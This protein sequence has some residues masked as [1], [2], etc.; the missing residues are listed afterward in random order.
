LSKEL[1]LA[2]CGL[3]AIVG[4]YLTSHNWALLCFKLRTS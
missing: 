3:D 4:Y 2:I 1:F